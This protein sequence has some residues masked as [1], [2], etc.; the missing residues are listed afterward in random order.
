MRDL[1]AILEHWE[2]VIGLE[3]HAQLSTRTK[4]FC[5]C[6]N[7]YGAPPNSYTCPTCLGLPGALPVAN[8]KAVNFALRLGLALGC[9]ITQLSRFARKNYFYPDL[10]KGYQISQYDDPL[11]VG[12]QVTIRWGNEI[13]DIAL[14][15]IHMEEDAGKSIHAE[16]GDGTK[17]DFNRCGVPL[18]EIVS[19]P[20]IQSPEEAKVYLVRLKQILEY[21]NIC[22]CNM[23]EG[24]LRCDANISVRPLGESKFGVKTEMK[25]MNSFRGVER[26]LTSEI[27]RQAQVLDEG[28]EV[29]QV[30]L[31]WNEA[32][33]KAEVMRSK[34]EA[35]DY[36]YFPDPD[37]VPLSVSDNNLDAIRSSL[38]EMP[39]ER[40][41]RFV[42]QYG[43]RL[44]DVLVLSSEKL[45]A[46]YFEETVS[47]GAEPAEA[48]KWIMG[49]VLSI[50]KDG[51]MSV[52]SF[53][54]TPDQFDGLLNSVKNGTVNVATGK[55]ILRRMVNSD[56]TAAE[57]I[58]KEGLAQVSDESALS[59]AVAQVVANNPDELGRYR[60]G[61]KALFGFFMGEVMKVTGG[62]SDPK[63]VKKLLTSS[64]ESD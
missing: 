42:N 54:V 47:A 45:L 41:E 50:I 53:P 14:T 9:E 64:L 49:E 46:D 27:V 34:E 24:N 19:E 57:I 51:R 8:E 63:V 48:A 55:D 22:N 60:E 2:P 38:V 33:Q 7:S 5:G 39:Y 12:G 25:N 40:E 11:C 17:V 59:E 16:N 37:L 62:K 61:K 44:K 56:L 32:E 1:S 21:L 35:H 13:K 23:E 26:G 3:V 20:V 58:K 31:L 28:G 6:R 30:T 15:R 52:S 36:R 18:V 43:L 4:M 29:E 10:T